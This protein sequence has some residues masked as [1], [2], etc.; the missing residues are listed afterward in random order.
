MHRMVRV[1][2]NHPGARS[3]RV[4]VSAAPADARIR[5]LAIGG[6]VPFTSL[7]F[8]GR[9]AAVVFCQGCP[10]RCRYCHNPH[11]LPRASGGHAPSWP[12][13]RTWLR[14]RRG[15][16]D[17]VVF[18]GGEPTLQ[19]GLGP[20]LQDVRALGFATGLHTAGIVPRRLASVLA[21]VDW[22]GF[23]LKAPHGAYAQVTGRKRSGDA[24]FASLALVLAAGIACEVRTTVHPV[25][26]PPA[27]LRELAAMLAARG[28][29]RWVLQR[30]RAD[31]CTDGELAA[32]GADPLSPDVLGQLAMDVP[33]IVVR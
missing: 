32:T 11:L 1:A 18:S 22:I 29:D 3:R 20:A 16:L 21:Y 23:D 14:T 9:L 8:P 10:W 28:V 12:A 4:V 33:H 30:F 5:A 15:L 6:L 25:L 2:T 27:A 19:A 17:A 24:A 31:G 26:T 7:D 13:V